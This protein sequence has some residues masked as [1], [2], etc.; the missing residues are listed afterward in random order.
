MNNLRV[1]RF[2]DKNKG[3]L[4]GMDLASLPRLHVELAAT[5]EY[6]SAD[7][8]PCVLVGAGG[9]REGRKRE[10]LTRG[11]SSPECAPFLYVLMVLVTR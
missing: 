1:R 6:L 9:A 2:H 11:M 10:N 3:H 4:N 8:Y 5:Q 7:S